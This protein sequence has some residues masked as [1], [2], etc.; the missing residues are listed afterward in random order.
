MDDQKQEVMAEFWPKFRRLLI[1]QVK[2]YVDAARDLLFSPLAIIAFIVD[3][4]R[5]S[6]N[7][8]SIFDR[9]LV[10]GRDTE[11]AINLFNQHDQDESEKANLDWLLGQVEERLREEYEKRKRR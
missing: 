8:D 2:L 3:L 7:D 5:K 4:I 11:R 1:F 10:L 6:D 9:V